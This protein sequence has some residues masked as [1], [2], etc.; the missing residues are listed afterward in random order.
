MRR[1]CTFLAVCVG[2]IM[3]LAAVFVAQGKLDSAGWFWSSE[4]HA[5]WQFFD[6]AWAGEQLVFAVTLETRGWVSPPPPALSVTLTFSSFGCVPRSQVVSLPKVAERGPFVRYFGQVLLSRRDLGFGSY[7]VV[8]LRVRVGAEVGVH[9][10]T[11]SPVQMWAPVGTV[12]GLGGPFV[13]AGPRGPQVSLAPPPSEPGKAASPKAI[14]E[15]DEPEEAPWL[16]PGTYWGELGWPGPGQNVDSRDWFRAN[17]N[18]GQILELRISTPRPV[19]VCLLD[20][21]GQEVGRLQGQGQL[22]LVY[23]ASKRGAHYIC[24]SI[25]DSLPSFTYTMELLLRR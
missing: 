12:G 5:Q 1:G 22:G 4:V 6:L 13:P 21:S 17:L 23:E 9:A 7:L 10:Q 24:V 11:I 8:N 2:Q 25:V 20:P 15:C 3:G 14:R 18:S 19:V 16:S